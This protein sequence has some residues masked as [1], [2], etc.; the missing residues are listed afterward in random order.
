MKN[1]FNQTDVSEI[2]ARLDSLSPSLQNQWGKMN[3]GQMLAHLNAAL[4]TAMGLNAPKRL[5]IGRILGPLVKPTYLSEKPFGRNSPTDKFYLFTDAREFEKEKAKTIKL[6][7]QFQE[8]GAD[9]CT[10]SPHSFFG[11]LT[12][13]EWAISQW[14]HFDHH[15]RQ[16]N[17]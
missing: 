9:K 6:V 13:N 7:K 15:L 1:L 12:P 16:F 2:L 5:F 11:K 3:V 10:T 14:K 17:C 4:E 8:G